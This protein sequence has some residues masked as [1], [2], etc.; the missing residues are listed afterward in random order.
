MSQRETRNLQLVID[1]IFTHSIFC[2]KCDYN[3][4]TQF[5]KEPTAQ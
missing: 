5:S 2:T 4:V 3:A 1:Q